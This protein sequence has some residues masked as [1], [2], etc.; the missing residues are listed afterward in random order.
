MKKQ[1]TYDLY[2]DHVI[3][4]RNSGFSPLAIT[5]ELEREKEAI[6]KRCL[7]KVSLMALDKNPYPRKEVNRAADECLKTIDKIIQEIEAKEISE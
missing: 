1:S 7:Q 5:M 2:M 6:R 4:A 3:R